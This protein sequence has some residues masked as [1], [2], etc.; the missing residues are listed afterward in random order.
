[1]DI[2][3]WLVLTTVVRVFV[4]SALT[5]FFGL[6]SRGYTFYR[7]AFNEHLSKSLAFTFRV[8]L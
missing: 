3:E 1:M 5:L 6:A 2:V 8:Y 4:R 7:S